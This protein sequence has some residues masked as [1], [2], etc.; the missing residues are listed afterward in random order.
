MRPTTEEVG[1]LNWDDQLAVPEKKSGVKLPVD[2]SQL[3]WKLGQK[4]KQEPRFWFYALYDR[5][6]RDDVLASSESTSLPYPG[7]RVVLHPSAAPW[8]AAFVDDSRLT[9]C[10]CLGSRE[11]G[12]AGCGKSARPV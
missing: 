10:A 6:T 9:P 2:V 3:R 8:P 12:Q 5:I 11:F 1:R 7:R 4:A